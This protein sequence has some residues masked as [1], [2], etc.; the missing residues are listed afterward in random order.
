MAGDVQAA[1]EAIER[2]KG[3]D[4][5]FAGTREGAFL[6]NLLRHEAAACRDAAWGDDVHAW[7]SGEGT[8][9]RGEALVPPGFP[10]SFVCAAQGF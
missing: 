9:A 7:R 1:A 3:M 10:S 8:G 2:Y 4:A 5:S 6:D